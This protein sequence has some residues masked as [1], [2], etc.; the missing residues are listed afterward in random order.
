MSL[1]W[2]SL[3]FVFIHSEKYAFSFLYYY[4][5]FIC[6]TH[7]H[8]HIHTHVII[9]LIIILI[10]IGLGL[11]DGRVLFYKALT[12]VQLLFFHTN[13]KKVRSIYM[14]TSSVVFTGSDDGKITR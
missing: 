13:Y 14:D 2:C 9:I 6:L 5:S 8:T 1:L 3:L 12:G 10:I 11:N 4:P 7:T